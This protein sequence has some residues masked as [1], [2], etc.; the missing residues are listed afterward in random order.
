M[1]LQKLLLTNF[2]NYPEAAL[3]FS[4]KINCFI[5]DNG[6]GKTNLL[7]AVY[8]LSFCKSY[9]N[10][11]DTQNIRHDEE[12]FA[13]H[14]TYIKNGDHHDKVSCLQKANQKKQFKL[15]QKDYDRL[16][17]HIGLYPLVMVSP[18]DSDLINE[19][20]EV[21]RKF[22]DGVISQF[23][24]IYLDDLLKYNKVLLQRN[25]LLKNFGVSQ[26]Y[27]EAALEPWDKI[28]SELGKKLYKSRK[29]FIT[30]FQPIFQEYFEYI[31]GGKE[32]VS[33]SYE[34][35][36]HDYDLTV[37]LSSSH[38]RDRVLKYTSAG[39]HKDDLFFELQDRPMK[40]YGS[41]GQQKSFLIAIKLAEFDYIKNI[42]GFKPILLF[43]DIFD[44]LDDFRVQQI[45]KLVSHNS[46]GQVFITDTQRHRI[47]MLFREVDIDHKIFE[48][49]NGKVNEIKW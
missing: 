22:M 2:K 28:L 27:Q 30:Q 17:D 5:G 9:F 10:P 37:L 14:G 47:E 36:L 48:V 25:I 29:E 31:S 3:S 40:K 7:D 44:K 19:G 32:Q 16:A 49:V 13:I 18:Y 12:F 38:D 24:K 43:D 33:V 4:D 35:Q 34:S 11:I 46:F 8:Y 15:N 23:D 26:D 1:Y 41:Q 20:S 21:R 6:V 45:I 39:T 42:K